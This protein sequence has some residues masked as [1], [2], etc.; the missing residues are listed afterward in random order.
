[1]KRYWTNSRGRGQAENFAPAFCVF[2]KKNVQAVLPRGLE[3]S[4]THDGFVAAYSAP[5]GWGIAPYAAFFVGM[6]VK[7]HSSPDGSPGLFIAEGFY[8]GRTGRVMHDH[9]NRRLHFGD[10]DHANDGIETR[11]SA[12]HRNASPS[13][14]V[15]I[16]VSG[17]PLP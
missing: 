13:V 12:G 8:T 17:E 10:V 6:F 2:D 16:K 14:A 9:Y 11:A 7:G 4:D 5:S 3:A 15:R 1:M